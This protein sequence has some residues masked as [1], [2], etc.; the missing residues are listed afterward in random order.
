MS[1]PAAQRQWVCSHRIWAVIA[2]CG[3]VRPPSTLTMDCGSVKWQPVISLHRMHSRVLQLS[4][5]FE[6]SDQARQ[7]SR[8]WCVYVICTHI[9]IIYA[10]YIFPDATAYLYV[11]TNI[12]HFFFARM[13]NIE[14]KS[15]DWC[16]LDI[17]KISRKKKYPNVSSTWIWWIQNL[18][19][20]Y[21]H[22]RWDSRR[23]RRRRRKVNK[24]KNPIQQYYHIHF[25]CKSIQNDWNTYRT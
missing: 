24:R 7:V 17:I 22:H 12:V 21:S 3:Y 19:N 10:V 16:C 18:F 2:P 1:G 23:Y 8:E 4:L 15:V 14:N 25:L 13:H 5:L 20:F 6:V 9:Y 11:C